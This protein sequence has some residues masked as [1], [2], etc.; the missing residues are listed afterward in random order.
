MALT[1]AIQPKPEGLRTFSMIY[2]KDLPS[3]L[4][5]S[6]APLVAEDDHV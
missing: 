4:S 1:A 5:A 3:E 2:L 6:L